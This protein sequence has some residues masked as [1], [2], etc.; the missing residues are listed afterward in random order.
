MVPKLP[1]LPLSILL[2]T[3]M[4][5]CSGTGWNHPHTSTPAS[6]IPG[7]DV[8]HAAAR[9]HI[10]TLSSTRCNGQ[11]VRMEVLYL[12]LSA[13]CAA[14][15]PKSAPVKATGVPTAVP[16]NISAESGENGHPSMGQRVWGPPC[17]PH[18]ELPAGPWGTA[19]LRLA[20]GSHPCEGTVQVQHHGQ[21]MPVCRGSWSAA[22]SQEL[23]HHL[24]CGDAEGD[25]VMASLD[26]DR[27]F[28]KG[29]P[30][31]VANCSGWEPQLCQLQLATEPSC[32][33]AGP[34]NV[35][36]TGAP[37][38]RLAG[39]RSR[40]EGRV[41]LRQ[42]GSWGTVCDDG[43]DLADAAVVCR[44][45][46]CGWAL[47]APREAAFGRGHG[48]VLLD[49][50][51]CSGHEEKLGEC[52]AAL[53]HDCSH[54][55]DASVVCS[56]HHEWRLSGGKDGCAGR[57]EVHYRGTWS[58]VCD[59]TWYMLE[60]SVLCHTLGCGEP[61]QRPS[62]HHTLPTKMLYECPDWQ[63][64][65]AYCRWTYN[66]SAPCHESRAAGVVCNGSLG[67]QTPT[68]EAT[69]MPNG[70]TSPS[71]TK[72]L[73]AAGGLSPLHMPLFIP[74]V[75][76]AVLLLLALVVFTTALLHLRKRSALTLGTPV[77]LLVTHSSQGHDMPLETCNNYR[78]VP[79]DLPKE[80]DSTPATLPTT[81]GSDSSDSDYEHY[82][83][84]SK[85]PVALST[86]HNSQRRQPVPTMQCAH[87]WDRVR[88]SSSSSSSSSMEPY[89]SENAASTGAWHCPQPPSCSTQQHTAPTTPPAAPCVPI[90]VLN[91]PWVSPP[92]TDP[93]H[94]DSSSTS[95]GE[96]YEN[97]QGA[98]TYGDPSLKEHTQDPSF[99]EGSDYDDIQG[100]GC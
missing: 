68:L 76:L 42:A 53:Q 54:K 45:L 55:E 10:P 90:P 84:S 1:P 81:K 30:A 78:E 33:A 41:E 7:P 97:V 49:E 99:S 52:P 85:P 3:G 50:V 95:S 21:W 14:A 22:A 87:P 70:G 72:G 80:P 66:K 57:V 11:E 6:C 43:W 31:A 100:S 8:Q 46:G 59:S 86:F 27:D 75:V 20:G 56:E 18:P 23:C 89:C 38:L 64:S 12:L 19:T 60:A 61:L 35:T 83:F 69:V 29:C 77:P 74:C 96:W 98:E 24:H 13:L 28:S 62:F 2:P 40:C 91:T 48:P 73:D 15:V 51:N 47:R 34:A 36:C 63:P 44:Q 79:A 32:C 5:C 9:D 39:G 37:A 17:H 58:T 71:T 16:S 82:D 25:A 94:A 93:D 67:L 26:S 92:P 65:L 4:W 88:S